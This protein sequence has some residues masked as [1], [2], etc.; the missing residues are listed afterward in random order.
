MTTIALCRLAAIAPGGIGSGELPD[1]TKVAIYRV[2][3]AVYVTD[4][5]CTHGR[6]SLSEEGSLTGQIVECGWHYGA[7]DVRTGEATGRPCSLPLRTYPVTTR[8]G[9]IHIELE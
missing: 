7:F 6:S 2:G 4:D 1:G 5:L 8:D 9:R 3:D